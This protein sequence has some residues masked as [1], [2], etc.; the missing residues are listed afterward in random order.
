[1]KLFIRNMACQSCKIVVKEELEKVGVHPQSVELGEAEVKEKLS[2]EQQNKFSHA[3]R[4]AG[5]ELIHNKEGILLEKIKKQI[6]DFVD[7][8]DERLPK[9]FSKFL[10]QKLEYSYA[11]L[12]SFFSAMEASTIEK[13]IIS[14]K[15]EKAKELILF[16]DYTLT[17]IAYKLNYSSV[18]HLSGQFKKITGLTPSHFNAL[19][20]KRKIAIQD[21]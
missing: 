4:K 13:Y 9:N 20:I 3:I 19:K 5:L 11:Y 12:A 15:I 8:H 10:S 21:I 17:E 14:L 18:A 16:H 7:H 1:M 6:H 2:A